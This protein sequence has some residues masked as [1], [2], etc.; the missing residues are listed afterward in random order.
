MSLSRLP[1]RFFASSSRSWRRMSFRFEVRLRPFTSLTRPTQ[2]SDV[3]SFSTAA[4]SLSLLWKRSLTTDKGDALILIFL[5]PDGEPGTRLLAVA[6]TPRNRR[7]GRRPEARSLG[8]ERL[9][10]E[11]AVDEAD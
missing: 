9:P 3:A 7:G 11:E 8:G 6:R 5:G 2:R 10:E 4:T 1:K